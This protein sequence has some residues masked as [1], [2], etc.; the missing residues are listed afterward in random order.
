MNNVGI[1]GPGKVT[2]IDEAVWQRTI[3]VDLKSV[4]FMS[5]HAVPR[6]AETGGGA[7]INVSS[8]DGVRAGNFHNIPYAAAKGGMITITRAMAVHHGREG[9][10]VNAILPGHIYTPMVSGV[11]PEWREM[12]RKAGPLGTEGTGW[13]IAWAAVFLASDEARW[14]SGVAL[15]VD[16][17][18]LAA[19]P[20]SVW[21]NLNE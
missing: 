7:I 6:M 10:R 17:G 5:K 19:T 9:V 4:V 16:A 11:T 14:I 18:L 20:L 2:E 8:I 3:D 21:Q 1:H 12:R 13:D 15:P